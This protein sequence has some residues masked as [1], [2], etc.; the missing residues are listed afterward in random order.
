MLNVE[1]LIKFKVT[2]KCTK[3]INANVVINIMWKVKFKVVTRT[4]SPIVRCG[5][6]ILHNAIVLF[7][8]FFRLRLILHA[9]INGVILS[10]SPIFTSGK[11]HIA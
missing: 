4:R 8:D 2:L 9:Y 6:C 5:D 3:K 11:I 1:V 10:W 7:F